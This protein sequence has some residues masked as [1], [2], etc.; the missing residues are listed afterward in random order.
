MKIASMLLTDHDDEL[1]Q[2]DPGPLRILLVTEDEQLYVSEFLDVFLKERKPNNLQILGITIDRPFHESM[3][4][5]FLRV[6][7]LY[8]T[9]D[10][11]HLGLRFVRAGLSG[12]SV[13]RLARRYGLRT[14]AP[15][16]VNHSDH[17]ALARELAPD[18]I[19]S[20]AAP[21]VFSPALLAV[22][23]LGCINIHS[24]RLPAYR[25]MLPSFWQM[26]RGE[27]AATVT[28]H[29]MAPKV[30]M[31]DIIATE[32]YPILSHDSLDR[33]VRE[34]KRGGARLMLRTLEAIRLGA[35]A[36][37]A[38]NITDSGYFS[39]PKSSDARAFRARGH[40]FL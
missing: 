37:S 20:V 12:R 13:H 9:L 38:Q 30:D 40:R 26:L 22:P 25:G 35:A 19:V 15:C 6:H 28:V 4:Q 39:F 29:W 16:S 21:E 31:G 17:L 3:A 23:R 5:T 7:E 24:G 34:T 1:P 10:T 36:R 27:P 18:L 8:G 2:D 32:Q 14:F 11:I 33:L